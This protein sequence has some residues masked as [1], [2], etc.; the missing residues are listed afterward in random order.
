[1]IKRDKKIL[2]IAGARPNFVKIAPVLKQLRRYKNIHSFLVHTGQ[3][4]DKEMSKVF[5]EDLHLPKPDI[6]LNV[7]SHNQAKQTAKIMIGLESVLVREKPDLIIVVGDVNSTLAGALVASKLS[8]P[9]AHIEAGLRSFDR[10]M[11]EEINRLITD[12]LSQF[13]FTPS[14]DANENLYR[15]GISKNKI[16]FVGNVMIDSLMEFKDII[17]NNK[18]LL[19]KLRLSKKDFAILTLHRPS[20]VDNARDIKKIIR[21]LSMIQRRIK[22]VFPVHPRTRFF[23]KKFGFSKLLSNLENLHLVEPL[24]YLDFLTLINNSLFVITDS[25][26]IQEE[27]TVL[28]VPCLTVRE[29]TERPVTIARGTNTIVGTNPDTL[30]K[31]SFNILSGIS[32]KG[33][34]PELWDGKASERIVKILLSKKTNL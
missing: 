20:N 11:P 27:T 23:L 26:G 34:V 25:G 30:I 7:G 4:Y 14:R 8:I 5:F 9:I 28:G 12:S 10:S 19:N 24:G 18:G 21:G 6:C 32:K 3:H 15:E 29:N 22:I 1:M 31:E 17:C 13:L 16:Y 2:S 33:R